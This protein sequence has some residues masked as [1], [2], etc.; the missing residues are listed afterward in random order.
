MSETS[1]THKFYESN[2]FTFTKKMLPQLNTFPYSPSIIQVFENPIIDV[3]IGG[4]HCLV[5]DSKYI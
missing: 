3:K 5:L 2:T 1:K 4:G